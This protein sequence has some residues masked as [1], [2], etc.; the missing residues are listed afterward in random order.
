MQY[1]NEASLYHELD[2]VCT[3]YAMSELIYTLAQ[4]NYARV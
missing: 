2:I 3:S 1:Q 4:V